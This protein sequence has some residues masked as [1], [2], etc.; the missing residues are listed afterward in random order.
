MSKLTKDSPFY[1]CLLLSFHVYLVRIFDTNN[2][3]HQLREQFHLQ[4]LGRAYINNY[5]REDIPESFCSFCFVIPNTL[6]ARVV[7]TS[8]NNECKTPPVKQTAHL[9]TC[10]SHS[11]PITQTPASLSPQ[12]IPAT[13]RVRGE[14]LRVGGRMG[15]FPCAIFSV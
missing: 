4:Y 2:Y 10:H 11:R 9:F 13:L 12:Y 7:S 14:G 15:L 3:I 8:D 1:T 6:K 5:I